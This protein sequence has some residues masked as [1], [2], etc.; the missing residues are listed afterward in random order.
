MEGSRACC[1]APCRVP[2][3]V[4]SVRWWC[5]GLSCRRSCHWDGAYQPRCPQCLTRSCSRVWGWWSVLSQGPGSCGFQAEHVGGHGEGKV[6]EALCGFS[7]GAEEREGLDFLS[8]ESNVRALVNQYWYIYIYILFF[9]EHIHIFYLKPKYV[10]VF[11]YHFIN[12]T[13]PLFPAN[14]FPGLSC[15]NLIVTCLSYYCT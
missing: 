4:R 10:K 13:I 2:R 6:V 5:W 15:V 8:E 9:Q 12:L 11:H 14:A 1:C 7:A 3:Q